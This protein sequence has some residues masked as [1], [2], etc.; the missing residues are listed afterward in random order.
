MQ[1]KQT[2]LWID[3]VVCKN[4]RIISQINKGSFGQIYLA[5]HQVKG[6]FYAVKIVSTGKN[7]QLAQQV[8]QE[9]EVLYKLNGASGFPRLL[10]FVQDPMYSHIVQTLLGK[11]LYQLFEECGKF[12]LKTVIKFMIQALD[13]LEFLHQN[14]YIH[15]DIKPE[16]FVVGLNDKKIYLIDF[17]FCQKYIENGKHIEKI[18]NDK[19]IGTPRFCPICAHLNITQNRASDL[20]SLGYLGIY[21]LKGSLPW[22][23]VN[24]ESKE[25]KLKIIGQK[26]MSTTTEELWQFY[27]NL[28]NSFLFPPSLGLP[29]PFLEYM[30][31]VNQISFDG[32]PNYSF[33]RKLFEKLQKQLGYPDDDKY[34]WSQPIGGSSDDVDLD[35]QK[36]FLEIGRKSFTADVN[37]SD[38]PNQIQKQQKYQIIQTNF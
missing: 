4:Y 16:N 34:D 37:I 5:T 25:D 30:K 32:E 15:R 13:R 8:R 21:F 2:D 36:V 35:K 33:T 29:K 14:Q 27:L 10:Y 28:R 1:I 24:A 31:Y 26:K 38:V 3:K 6:D 18:K 22:M 20:E 19:M 12:T 17:G 11:N 23:H 7:T 9:A